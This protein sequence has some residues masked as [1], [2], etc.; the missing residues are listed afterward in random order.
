MEWIKKILKRNVGIYAEKEEDYPRIKA[1]F[2]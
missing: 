2:V 1:V